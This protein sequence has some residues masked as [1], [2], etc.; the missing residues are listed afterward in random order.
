MT[1]Q[2]V[3]EVVMDANCIDVFRVVTD[4]VARIV[5]PI[6][7]VLLGRKPVE[8]IAK[9]RLSYIEKELREH[10]RGYSDEEQAFMDKTLNKV[11]SKP[12]MRRFW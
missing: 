4:V 11:F 6:I 2:V 10:I 12:E 7:V 3:E 9:S 5:V 1:T 8:N